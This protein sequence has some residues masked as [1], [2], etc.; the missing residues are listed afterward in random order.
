MADVDYGV[1]AIDVNDGVIDLVAQLLMEGIFNGKKASAGD[2][3]VAAAAATALFFRRV[4]LFAIAAKI[5]LD[6]TNTI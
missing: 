1:I 3:V 4:S 6:S 5:F 2:M